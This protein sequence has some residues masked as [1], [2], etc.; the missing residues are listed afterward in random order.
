MTWFEIVL[1]CHQLNI[2]KF[3]VKVKISV[4]FSFFLKSEDV[5]I[6]G[7]CGEPTGD[8]WWQLPSETPSLRF[9]PML[10]RSC[11]FSAW[12]QRLEGFVNTDLEQQKL[13]LSV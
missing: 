11:R 6:P 8:V 1:N 13:L 10:L 3:P 9:A 12:S 7:F 2:V 4:L 5:G